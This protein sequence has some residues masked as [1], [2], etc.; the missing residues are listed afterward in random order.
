VV[1]LWNPRTRESLF[2]LGNHYSWTDTVAFSSDSRLLL[3]ASGGHSIRLWSTEPGPERSTL[4]GHT[5]QVMTAVFSPDDTLIASGSH[6]CNVVLWDVEG[7]KIS[8]T[9]QGHEGCVR[10]VA[11]SPNGKYVASG[12]DDNTTRL[13]NIQSRRTYRIYHGHSYCVTSVSFLK[14]GDLIVSASMDRTIRIWSRTEGTQLALYDTCGFE[15]RVFLSRDGRWLQTDR[16]TVILSSQDPVLCGI[17]STSSSPLHLDAG[18]VTWSS[19]RLLW[20]PSEYRTGR[21]AHTRTSS[22]SVIH[23]GTSPL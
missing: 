15:K 13:W 21:F 19:R 5:D 8:A 23:Q 17:P 18:W 12:S 3:S 14:D 22:Q 6:D 4:Q 2:A 7:K 9:L 11:F 16:G 10:T 1:R 20:L